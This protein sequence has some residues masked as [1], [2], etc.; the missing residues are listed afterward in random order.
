[1][2]LNISHKTDYLYSNN[3]FFEPHYLRFKP[4]NYPY[5][6]IDSFN[7]QIDPNPTGFTEQID[8]EN[9]CIQFLWFDNKHQRLSISVNISIQVSEYNSFNFLIYPSKYLKIPF[10][11]NNTTSQLLKPALQSYLLSKSIQDFLNIIVKRSENNTMQFLT[12]LTNQIYNDFILESRE[13]GEPYPPDFTFK[14]KKGSCRDLAW[15][16][17]HLLR[18]MGIASRFVSGYYCLITDNSKFELHAWIETFLPGAGWIGF[19]PSHGIM[20]NCLHIPLAS[21]VFYENT[22]PVTGSVRGSAKHTLE[23]ELKI[24][25]IS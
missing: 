5:L 21:S 24:R 2:K 1:M 6:N 16:Q 7:V 15:M 10:N 9:N 25:V 8:I 18:Y 12:E 3:V 13:V 23:N 22:M 17:I 20:T 11:Y 14:I 4:K 19:D